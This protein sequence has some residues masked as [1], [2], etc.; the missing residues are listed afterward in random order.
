MV[1]FGEMLHAWKLMIRVHLNANDGADI[2]E[3]EEYARGLEYQHGS[4]F[5]DMETAA[6]PQTWEFPLFNSLGMYG[7][8]PMV[9]EWAA[10]GHMIAVRDMTRDEQMRQLFPSTSLDWRQFRAWLRRTNPAELSWLDEWCENW[11]A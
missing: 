11:H 5:I 7:P 10:D 9:G 1:T 8:H 3:F 6:K 2:W 4:N